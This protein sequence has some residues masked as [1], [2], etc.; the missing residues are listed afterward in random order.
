[1]GYL[2]ALAI[3][4]GITEFLPVSSSAHLV[5]FPELTGHADQGL[6]IDI[7]VHFGSLGAVIIYNWK[8][9]F[10]M[11]LSLLTLGRLYNDSL[12][13]TIMALTAT[14]PAILIG[15]FIS[16]YDIIDLYLR[17]LMVIGCATI[18]FGII[19]GIADR[20]ISHRKI[21]SIT[22]YD[23]MVV[24]LAQ[25]LAFI[26]GTSRSGICMTM[27]RFTGLTRQASAQFAMILSIP[28]IIGASVKSGRDII[29]DNQVTV[30]NAAITAAGLAFLAAL[31]SIAAM[32]WMI[33]RLGMMPF[34][35]YRIALGSLLIGIAFQI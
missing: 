1:M 10:R 34:V 17:N 29:W 15:Y 6:L 16:E 30:M 2:V 18:F 27:A 9:L 14:L 5:I 28:V 33:E 31:V 24:G 11:G 4:Q 8:M 20:Q 23:A 13:I 35:I 19:L 22:F 25:P 7:A 21:T 26:P 12:P 3:I 32:M